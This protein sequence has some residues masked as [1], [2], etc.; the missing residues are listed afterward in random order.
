MSWAARATI[1]QVAREHASKLR[2]YLA[3]RSRDMAA[4]EDALS[5]AF[6]KALETWPMRGAPEKPAAWLLTVAKRR[7]GHAA[8]HARVAQAAEPEL[9]RVVEEA[10]AHG[11]D[12]VPDERLSL[13]LACARSEVSPEMRA[14][15]MLQCV[16]GLSAKRIGSAF[17][18][19]PATMGQRLSREKAR[20]KSCGLRFE[21]PS[22]EDRSSTTAPTTSCFSERRCLKSRRKRRLSRR[23][24]QPKRRSWPAR[25]DR[26]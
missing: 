8:R 22:A 7:L 6:E 26:T 11:A 2:A 5:Y 17:L 24:I 20:L 21:R 1:D 13:L 19:P 15:L 16:M 14:P 12:G 18:T 4:A 3:A 23:P 9:L 25:T 10:A